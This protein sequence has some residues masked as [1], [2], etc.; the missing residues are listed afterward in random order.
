MKIALLRAD[1]RKLSQK[2]I[3]FHPSSWFEHSATLSGLRDRQTG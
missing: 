3:A 1:K 2:Q